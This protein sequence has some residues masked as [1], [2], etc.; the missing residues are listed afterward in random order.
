M[1]IV[2]CFLFK[3]G[4]TIWTA[5]MA[6]AIITT[7]IVAFATMFNSK[8]RQRFELV[9]QLFTQFKN[10]NL[11]VNGHFRCLTMKKYDSV[12][13]LKVWKDNEADQKY[14][15]MELI[16]F[17]SRLGLYLNKKVIKPEEIQFYFYNYLFDEEKIK[18]LISNL[19]LIHSNLLYP[20]KYNLNYLFN[21]ISNYSKS[22]GK[23]YE[24]KSFYNLINSNFGTSK[25]LS[26][27]LSIKEEII[28]K[29]IPESEDYKKKVSSL[30]KELN[31]EY[32]LV[33][34]VK[35]EFIETIN[36]KYLKK[37]IG[38]SYGIKIEILEIIRNS[39]ERNKSHGKIREWKRLCA[40]LIILMNST[41][42]KDINKK[43]S[44]DIIVRISRWRHS[45]GNIWKGFNTFI[46]DIVKKI[47]GDIENLYNRY[48]R[49]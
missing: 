26:E 27:V 38:L 41:D 14:W 23:E 39:L 32:R 15:S 44:A 17:L 43:M 30:L 11:K 36:E 47:W 21:E 25:I 35:D 33:E 6:I 22:F 8:K 34:R 37:I 31:E 24:I 7:A 13:S 5:V 45:T 1:K 9:N 40:G 19:K 16:L 46:C 42:L 12:E 18:N 28:Y 20:I 48:S 10:L 29:V 2:G 3:D 49:F 4:I